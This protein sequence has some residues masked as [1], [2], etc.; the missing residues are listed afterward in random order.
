MAEW[1]PSFLV[2]GETPGATGVNSLFANARTTVNNLDRNALRRG[3]IN[4]FCAPVVIPSG[5]P[6]VISWSGAG[7][8]TYSD[9]AIG[10]AIRYT[11]FGANGTTDRTVIGS[12]GTG[13]V[14]PS[15]ASVS[16]DG[17]GYLLG[18]NGTGSGNVQWIFAM[19]NV[20]VYDIDDASPTVQAMV[21]LQYKCSA[22]ATW[23]T[24]AKTE[25]FVSRDSHRRSSEAIWCD[26]PIRTAI[27]ST[28]L[29]NAGFNA[30]TARVT[31]VR[32]V[33]SISGGTALG[34]V[35]HLGSYRL[36]AI[37]ILSSMTAPA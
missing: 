7:T 25:R 4:R 33:C 27:T 24:L 11:T 19:F 2:D 30:A 14:N 17:T 37:P 35:L 6:K 12:T 16:F 13:A 23:Q 20:D 10:A 29:T 3:A 18:G 1:E 8:H 5:N 36:S 31:G 21:C 9:A 22:S 28:T 15:D 34:S 32:A 26:I